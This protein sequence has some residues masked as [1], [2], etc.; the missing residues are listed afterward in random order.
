MVKHNQSLIFNIN[1]ALVF[2]C[3]PHFFV[4]QPGQKLCLNNLACFKFFNN[5][6]INGKDVNFLRQVVTWPLQYYLHCSF[7][8][9]SFIA[10]SPRW[11]KTPIT[12]VL[13]M[14]TKAML[15]G[16]DWLL[17]SVVIISLVF[18]FGSAPRYFWGHLVQNNYNFC[19]LEQIWCGVKRSID[20]TLPPAQNRQSHMCWVHFYIS[21]VSSV[22]RMAL[23]RK[24]SEL[25]S[26]WIQASATWPRYWSI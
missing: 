10:Q 15:V 7:W 14:Y 19:P 25:W 23:F 3:V 24:R 16:V 21:M 22:L 17:A 11:I 5:I 2:A 20:L 18:C 8:K 26:K 12:Q 9:E 1:F 13:V 4:W 6:S